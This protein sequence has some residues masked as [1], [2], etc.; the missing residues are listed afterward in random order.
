M[1]FFQPE[2]I[3]FIGG[4]EELFVGWLFFFSNDPPQLKWFVLRVF[5]PVPKQGLEEIL[6]HVL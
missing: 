5:N 6:A 2:L 4:G 3:F 1:G